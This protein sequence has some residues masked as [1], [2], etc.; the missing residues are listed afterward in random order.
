[1]LHPQTRTRLRPPRQRLSSD[2]LLG[3]LP[4]RFRL[5]GH[6]VN[7]V[8]QRPGSHLNQ[9]LSISPLRTGKRLGSLIMAWEVVC[10]PAFGIGEPPIRNFVSNPVLGLV[11]KRIPKSF[12]R[13]ARSRHGS[14][15]LVQRFSVF[16]N[17]QVLAL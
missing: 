13:A 16:Q 6:S 8:R 15:V 11:G 4:D 3:Q 9:F 17:D 12:R 2:R 1:V 5:N 7:A 10:S 14:T